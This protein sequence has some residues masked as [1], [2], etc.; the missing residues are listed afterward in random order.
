M[1]SSPV[2]SSI[3]FPQLTFFLVAISVDMLLEIPLFSLEW[4]QHLL[5]VNFFY[6]LP[7]ITHFVNFCRSTNFKVIVLQC[8][9]CN[10]IRG[11]CSSWCEMNF[12][13]LSH[14]GVTLD[15]DRDFFIRR[16]GQLFTCRYLQHVV[17]LPL[18]HFNPHYSGSQMVLP[19]RS[20][21]IGC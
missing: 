20:A 12:I 13:R 19:H 1:V 14:D 9:T 5:S 15:V 2:R 4:T 21:L 17:S 11:Y 16:R 3:F 7:S 8:K 10:K 6:F 18:V